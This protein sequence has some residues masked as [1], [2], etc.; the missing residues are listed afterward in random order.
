MGTLEN[1][2]KWNE[3]NSHCKS[4]SSYLLPEDKVNGSSYLSDSVLS[5]TNSMKCVD[6][7]SPSDKYSICFTKA[8]RKYFRGAGS[9]I[10]TN[11][12]YILPPIVRELENMKNMK[13]R[14]FESEEIKSIFGYG[15]EFIFP[16]NMSERTKCSLL[17]NVFFIFICLFIYLEFKCHCCYSFN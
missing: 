1:N 15:K 14:Y 10:Q 11:T 9:I 17:G 2:Q 4:I 13:L 6:I 16:R 5:K 8:Y 3:L 12:P 7:I